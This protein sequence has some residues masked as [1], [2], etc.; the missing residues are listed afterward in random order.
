MGTHYTNL[1]IAEDAP[2]EVVRAAYRALALRYH[3]DKNPG[4]ADTGRTMQIINDAYATLSDPDKRKE[5]DASLA[6]R[7][8]ELPLIGE[9]AG[10]EPE[11]E[12]ESVWDPD[13]HFAPPVRHSLGERLAL[14]FLRHLR[15]VLLAVV[16][17]LWGI[18]LLLDETPRYHRTSQSTDESVIDYEP[19]QPAPSVP[20]NTRP[21]TAP[22]GQPWP[23]TASYIAQYK[24]LAA[25]G[26]SQVTVDNTPNDSDVFLKLVYLDAGKAYPVRACFL[27]ARSQF[28]L[29]DLAPGTYDLRYRNLSTGDDFKSVEFVLSQTD[30]TSGPDFS[31][32][33]LKL[34][35]T[36]GMRQTKPIAE[37]EF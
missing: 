32:L 11:T 15:L 27:P 13:P 5:Y 4:N 10:F 34:S 26:R 35:E 6:R 33:N 30:T 1:K 16:L 3:P 37:L 12:I 28:L 9:P 18:F 25:G 23:T 2:D 24:I 29:K 31:T 21:L 22:N 8:L 7:R 36:N 20:T 17:L 14:F 19:S